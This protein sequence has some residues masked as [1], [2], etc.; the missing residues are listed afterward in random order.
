M[1]TQLVQA[2]YGDE[3]PCENATKEPFPGKYETGPTFQKK[4]HR[5]AG[6]E[7]RPVET[8]ESKT[9]KEL[10]IGCLEIGKDNE[11]W[12]GFQIRLQA[13]HLS[14]QR[15]LLLIAL[16]VSS[17][18]QQY[19]L[20]V[21]LLNNHS[22]LVSILDLEG[23]QLGPELEH[24]EDPAPLLLASRLQSP[25]SEAGEQE[26]G[27]DPTGDKGAATQVAVEEQLLDQNGVKKGVN[28]GQNDVEYN[29]FY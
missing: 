10:W 22:G 13:A 23:L 20:E 1:E 14:L 17:D 19:H 4:S 8:E 27:D 18:K 21:E 9:V 24:E 2:K 3:S 7:Q 16:G 28:G 29:Q 26:V 12:Q 6:L 5:E 11:C 15:L 25:P